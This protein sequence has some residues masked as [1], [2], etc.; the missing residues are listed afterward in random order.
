MARTACL[1]GDYS[2]GATILSQL[3][4]ETKDPNYIYN[5]ARCFEQNSRYQEALSR[6]QE[7]LRVG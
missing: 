5:Q 7:Y 3:F 6:F 2:K 1:A 4:V